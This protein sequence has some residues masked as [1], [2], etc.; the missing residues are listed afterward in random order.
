[1]DEILAFLLNRASFLYKELGFRFVDSR[2]STSF[3]GDSLLVLTNDKIRFRIVRDRSQ[4]FGDFQSAAPMP[5]DKWFSIDVVRHRLTGESECPS[6]LDDE[7]MSFL[8]NQIGEI[9]KLFVESNL[10]STCNELRK[11]E[12]ER[13]KKLFG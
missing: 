7:N 11:L 6:E 1:M 8:R 5:K 9:E 2:Y 3:G 10:A 12:A 4:L 13:A